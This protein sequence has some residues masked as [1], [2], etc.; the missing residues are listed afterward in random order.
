MIATFQNKSWQG[1]NKWKEGR[2]G[3]RGGREGGREGGW[4]DGYLNCLS[5]SLQY[6][7]QRIQK[8]TKIMN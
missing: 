5:L 3:G 7:A 1:K 4:M 8:V 2:E 6:P